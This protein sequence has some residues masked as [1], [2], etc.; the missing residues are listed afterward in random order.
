M[1]GAPGDASA[2]AR[3]RIFATIAKSLA[4]G[5][6]AAAPDGAVADPAAADARIAARP[7]GRALGRVDR[8]PAGL[9]DLFVE[10]AAAVQAT[11]ARLD[12]PAAVPQAV[13]D[14]LAAQNQP[15]RLRCAP[16]PWLTGLDWAATALDVSA[17]RAAADDTA[18]LTGALAGVAETGTLMLVSG[19]A[20]PT[21]LNFLPDTHIVALKA[22]Q[23]VAS[24]EDGWDR[25]RAAGPM[26][27][28]VNMITGPS[29]TGDIEQVIQLGAHGPRRLHI[30]LV[31]GTEAATRAATGAGPDR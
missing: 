14:Y 1:S 8:D 9:I 23:V 20:G 17:G 15:A 30:L 5:R 3:A 12:G 19:P 11:V 16:E 21:T 24:Y 2:A 26:P 28:T 25:I 4:A 18:S 10:Q 6:I 22:D 31:G 13:A 27:R 29:R 7:R